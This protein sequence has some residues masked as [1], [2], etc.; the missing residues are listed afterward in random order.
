[1]VREESIT[2]DLV[3]CVLHVIEIEGVEKSRRHPHHALALECHPLALWKDTQ[4][5]FEMRR[6][7]ATGIRKSGI[8]HDL[9]LDKLRDMLRPCVGDQNLVHP[10]LPCMAEPSSP[11]C[12][13]GAVWIKS[14][15]DV[16]KSS[17]TPSQASL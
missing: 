11:S 9:Q 3:E 4:M 16:P 6:F 14:C 12:R 5:A 15:A 13:F 10:L 1:M 8:A 7:E 2:D 17:C